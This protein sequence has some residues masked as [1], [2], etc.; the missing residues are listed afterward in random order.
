MPHIHH[1]PTAGMR[2]STHKQ[3]MMQERLAT[4]IKPMV[5][6]KYRNPLLMTRPHD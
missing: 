4:A 3:G 6:K 1:L 2:T 5:D